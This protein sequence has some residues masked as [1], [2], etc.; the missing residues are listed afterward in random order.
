MP[1]LITAIAC[2]V[3]ASIIVLHVLI[4]LLYGKVA[5]V[6]GIVNVCLHILLIPMMLFL[7]AELELITLVIMASLFVY[8]LCAHTVKA[9]K[10]KKR[11]A[12]DCDV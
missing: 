10:K 7:G 8:L 4:C 6:L 3:F 5:S 2:V 11:G 1:G 9:A 12:E